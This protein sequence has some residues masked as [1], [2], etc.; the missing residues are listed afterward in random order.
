ML[1]KSVI[2]SSTPSSACDGKHKLS[3]F[4]SLRSLPPRLLIVFALRSASR[5]SEGPTGL[6]IARPPS[7]AFMTH[8]F[9][10]RSTSEIAAAKGGGIPPTQ[11]WV[12]ALG[13]F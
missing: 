11:D 2:P 9:T 13:S 12:Q 8:L 4:F 1:N 7:G 10:R 6:A 3:N 5:F